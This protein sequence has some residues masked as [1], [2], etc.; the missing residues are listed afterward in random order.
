MEADPTSASSD[1]MWEYYDV[2]CGCIHD[3]ASVN[4]VMVIMVNSRSHMVANCSNTDDAE[5]AVESVDLPFVACGA[6]H[7]SYM[8]HF[9]MEVSISSAE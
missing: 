4:T 7:N 3:C 1:G 5:P 8:F 6:L 2:T 9:G